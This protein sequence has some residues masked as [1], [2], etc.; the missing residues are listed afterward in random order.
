MRVQSEVSTFRVGKLDRRVPVIIRTDR[1]MKPDRRPHVVRRFA[2]GSKPAVLQIHDSQIVLGSPSV[3]YGYPSPSDARLYSLPP[4]APEA[5][6]K[7]GP[8]Q[9]NEAISTSEKVWK[10]GDAYEC[11]IPEN[12][13]VE[14]SGCDS[15][16]FLAGRVGNVTVSGCPIFVARTDPSEAHAD[17]DAKLTVS[18]SG[19]VRVAVN[20]AREAQFVG[21]AEVVAANLAVRPARPFGARSED[22]LPGIRAEGSGFFTAYV[23]DANVRCAG[24][25]AA[26]VMVDG[27]SE[28]TIRDAVHARITSRTLRAGMPQHVVADATTVRL[29]GVA[30]RVAGRPV[31]IHAVN[32]KVDG[33]ST[34]KES[35][36]A[37]NPR[38]GYSLAAYGIVTGLM[39][40]VVL[41][42]ESRRLGLP[43]PA[44][45]GPGLV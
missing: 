17:R 34:I 9:L 26:Q 20:D 1:T 31:T 36:S 12:T 15:A 13:H 11:W 27:R 10:A 37:L 28:A 14:I 30:A 39:P 44:A 23:R 19:I 7:M 3:A 32:S 4:L 42:T 38:T 43:E 22:P 41:Q 6:W 2:W 5:D 40:S 29:D 24:R 33:D 21:N 35:L 8:H 45:S 18:N 16:V 25:M